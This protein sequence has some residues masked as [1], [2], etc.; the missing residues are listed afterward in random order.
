MYRCN[1]IRESDLISI[2]GPQFAGN[3]I[4]WA[5]DRE[6]VFSKSA[7]DTHDPHEADD[8]LGVST[9]TYNALRERRPTT[10][11]RMPGSNSFR[12]LRIDAEKVA[13]P[14]ELYDFTRSRITSLLFFHDTRQ[15]Q[16][17]YLIESRHW[18]EDQFRADHNRWTRVRAYLARLQ[19]ILDATPP[20]DATPKHIKAI[21][22]LN[23]EISSLLREARYS[24]LNLDF[25]ASKI[26]FPPHHYISLHPLTVRRLRAHHFIPHYAFRPPN[27]WLS[28]C[29]IPGEPDTYWI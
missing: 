2:S 12:R 9:T 16:T 10:L 15:T 21:R 4:P 29:A 27:L 1:D 11:Y 8:A 19:R 26:P 6:R 23:R 28:A 17:P 25:K 5:L 14:H 18:T 24:T 7:S 3:N 13:F 20:K 22:S